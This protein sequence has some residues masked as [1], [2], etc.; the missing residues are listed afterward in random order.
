VT[1]GLGL[2]GDAERGAGDE[3][4]ADRDVGRGEAGDQAGPAAGVL[5]DDDAP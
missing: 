1:C 4:L 3:R 5:D 2:R